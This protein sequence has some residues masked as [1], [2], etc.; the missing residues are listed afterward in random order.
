[1]KSLP[2]PKHFSRSFVL[3][4]LIASAVSCDDDNESS[5]SEATTQFAQS[6]LTIAE[7]AGEQTITLSLDNAAPIDGEVFVEI[8]AITPACYSTTPLAELGQLK[9]DV[10]K[11]VRKASFKLT[12]TDNNNLDG[13]KTVKFKITTVSKGFITGTSRDLLNSYRR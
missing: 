5:F 11:G 12:P 10:S 3:F 1:M 9:V 7:N 6:E 4:G 13:L 8:N 2:S